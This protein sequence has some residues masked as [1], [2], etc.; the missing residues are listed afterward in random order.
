MTAKCNA[1]PRT[2]WD[3][4]RVLQLVDAHLAASLPSS[5]TIY[6]SSK[7]YWLQWL[8]LSERCGLPATQ[9]C[10]LAAVSDPQSALNKRGLMPALAF[11]APSEVATRHSCNL[12][13]S[14]VRSARAVTGPTGCSDCELQ[15]ALEQLSPTVLAQLLRGAARCAWALQRGGPGCGA[16]RAGFAAAPAGP[17]DD[18]APAGAAASTAGASASH[19][20]HITTSGFAA[21]AVKTTAEHSMCGPGCW[22]TG[23]CV[24]S[25]R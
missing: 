2:Q 14:S 10:I 19:G 7:A 13:T 4:Q 5:L 20:D 23:V 9:G 1:C 22:E 25:S 18:D 21:Q 3:I 11:F 6:R 24:C 12:Q 15:S 8:I 16:A 17:I